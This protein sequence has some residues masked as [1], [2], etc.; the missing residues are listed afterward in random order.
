MK[1]T[2]KELLKIA[3]DETRKIFYGVFLYTLEDGTEFIY[4]YETSL[5]KNVKEFASFSP[6]QKVNN[7]TTRIETATKRNEN[8]TIGLSFEIDSLGA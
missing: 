8:W 5:R 1:I 6:V 7:E 2:K 4:H 3:K